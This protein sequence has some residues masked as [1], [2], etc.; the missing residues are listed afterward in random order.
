MKKE[1]IL[2][3]KDKC[4]LVVLSEME[5]RIRNSWIFLHENA[6][7]R[8]LK[9]KGASY[10]ISNHMNANQTAVIVFE[11]TEKYS[12]TVV[13]VE[14]PTTKGWGK[15]TGIEAEHICF[16]MAKNDPEDIYFLKMDK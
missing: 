5:E 13:Y 12:K 8:L 14:V 3:P 9:S 10:S 11:A 16:G 1:V 2:V 15:V 6:Y 7:L 4:P